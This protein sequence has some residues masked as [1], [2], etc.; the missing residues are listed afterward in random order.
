MIPWYNGD[1]NHQGEKEMAVKRFN[2]LE[3]SKKLQNAGVNK[4]AADIVALELYS[5]I[6]ND[7]VTKDYLDKKL[8]EMELRLSRLVVRS[9][10]ILG[11]V[12]LTA[13][14]IAKLIH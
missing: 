6:G 11:S 12:V 1:V 5:I 7:L 10:L 14:T 3:C 13:I 8:N 2:P 4:E 9:H